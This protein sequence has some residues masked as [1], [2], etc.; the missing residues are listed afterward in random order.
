MTH[1]PGQAP[2][3]DQ[4]PGQSPYASQPDASSPQTPNPNASPSQYFNPNQPPQNVAP[5]YGAP[6]YGAPQYGAQFG[7][8]PG[9]PGSVA[10]YYSTPNYGMNQYASNAY[11][12]QNVASNTNQPGLWSLILGLGSFLFWILPIIGGLAIF[13][14][15]AGI[16]LGF[17]GLSKKYEGRRALAGWGLGVSI[18]ALLIMALLLILTLFAFLPLFFVTQNSMYD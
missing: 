16:I 4:Q 8:Q 15:V 10:P 7:T 9:V 1:Y 12:N 14:P 3:G 13:M 6:Q 5:Q 17:I 18:A 2:E 11:P